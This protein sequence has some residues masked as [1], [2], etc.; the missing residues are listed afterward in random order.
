M[1]VESL[2]NK[3]KGTIIPINP[4]AEE[5][6]GLQ[7]YPSVLAYKE[8][9]DLAV[10]S[11]PAEMTLQAIETCAKKMIRYVVL[12]TAGFAEIG[13]KE[14]EDEIVETLK[15]NHMR[16]LRG[17]RLAIPDTTPNP[18]PKFDKI[19]PSEIKIRS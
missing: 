9:I 1:I 3:F 8:S 5:I 2:K 19:F 16:L 7:A 18:D 12:V 14:L 6:Q 17:T 15:R 11:V 10:I 13:N 4:H